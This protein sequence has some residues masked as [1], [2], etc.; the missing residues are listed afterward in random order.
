MDRTS[1]YSN[2]KNLLTGVAS[3]AFVTPA[4]ALP[5]D[6]PI[7]VHGDLQFYAL[8]GFGL[9]LVA[10]LVMRTMRKPVTL[11]DASDAPSRYSGRFFPGDRPIALE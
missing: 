5:P 10:A 8:V 3:L 7:D 2:W 9:L 1:P 4:L 6:L 11:P